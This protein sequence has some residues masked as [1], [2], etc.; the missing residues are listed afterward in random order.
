ME[1]PASVTQKQAARFDAVAAQILAH[2]PLFAAQGTVT[3]DWRTYRG[4]RLGPYFRV[5]FRDCGR[6]KSSYLGRDEAL[7]ERV[8]RLLADLQELHRD[9]MLFRRLKAQVRVALRRQKD[10]LRRELAKW[11]IVLKGWEFRG[12][13]PWACAFPAWGRN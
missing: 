1:K 5:D 11:G 9:R 6:R 13:P 12:F 7:A 10:E 4:R 3:A 8:R 2:K